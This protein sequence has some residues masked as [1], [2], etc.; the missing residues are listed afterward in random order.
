MTKAR[1]GTVS[2]QVGDEAP[3]FEL[4]DQTRQ[5]VRLSDYL[6]KKHV[7]LV[8]FPL[9]FTGVCEGELCAIRDS[10]DSFRS[11]EVETLA[12]SV[13]MS[14]THAHW[15]N[16]Q[17]FDFPLLSD[18]WP[19]GAVARAYGVFDERTGLALRGTFVVAKD[20]RV[21]YTDCNAIPDARDQQAW[22]RA[23]KELGAL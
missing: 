9:P 10:L 11:D 15:A 3:D 23:L 17:G 8:F 7:L 16:E 20:G 18:F 13:A 1:S 12:V 2:V 21:A 19:H 4:V 14:P 5:P 22:K 6:G